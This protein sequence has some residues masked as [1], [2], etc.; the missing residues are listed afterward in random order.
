[1]GT[2]ETGGNGDDDDDD[3]ND[4]TAFS[5]SYS[6]RRLKSERTNRKQQTHEHTDLYVSPKKKRE[7]SMSS[8]RAAVQLSRLSTRAAAV[9]PAGSQQA[10]EKKIFLSLFRRGDT[11]RE[12]V[13]AE[14]ETAAST[15]QFKDFFYEDDL[16]G[17]WV[18]SGV[19]EKLARKGIE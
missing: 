12:V 2:R 19:A 17:D 11:R 16:Y 3:D 1:M 6:R 13:N 7:E 18:H 15:G 5:Q 4:E 10:K 14:K 9:R 8:W